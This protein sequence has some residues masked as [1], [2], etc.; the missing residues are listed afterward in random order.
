MY[1]W[2]RPKV[3]N[4]VISPNNL[5][6]IPIRFCTEP[7]NRFLL[8]KQQPENRSRS[9]Q[10]LFEALFQVHTMLLQPSRP[11]RSIQ[12]LS[13]S[14]RAQLLAVR[15]AQTRVLLMLQRPGAPHSKFPIAMAP[16]FLQPLLQTF[17]I[18]KSKQRYFMKNQQQYLQTQI[19][20]PT[21]TQRMV[22]I[23][24]V[25]QMYP[26]RRNLTRESQNEFLLIELL[27]TMISLLSKASTKVTTTKIVRRGQTQT[28]TSSL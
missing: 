11:V 14:T 24:T 10:L 12:N 25:I 23:L 8:L 20:H 17:Q 13:L 22:M 21:Q 9:R 15:I 26:S 28:Q 2:I 18:Q 5:N 16:M 3:Q 1:P 27:L 6:L 4:S 19:I 7:Q